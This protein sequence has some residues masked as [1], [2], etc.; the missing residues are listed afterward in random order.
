[1]L[2]FVKNVSAESYDEYVPKNEDMDIRLMKI[3]ELKSNP[4]FVDMTTA[5]NQFV[6]CSVGLEGETQLLS[7]YADVIEDGEFL[8]LNTNNKLEVIAFLTKASLGG[9]QFDRSMNMLMKAKEDGEVPLVVIN[10]K[11]DFVGL[12]LL[13]PL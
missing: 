5:I 7:I 10:S 11:K 2:E 1:M 13:H 9:E 3:F 8:V 4:R 12:K 6:G